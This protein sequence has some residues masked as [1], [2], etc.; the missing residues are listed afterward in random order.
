MSH[1]ESLLILTN[2]DTV[3]YFINT[4]HRDTDRGKKGSEWSSDNPNKIMVV[5]EITQILIPMFVITEVV[6]G[7]LNCFP[8]TFSVKG[9]GSS[10]VRGV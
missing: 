10:G 8:A 1:Y 9:F 3:V 7:N 4:G 6:Y 2:T 5:D